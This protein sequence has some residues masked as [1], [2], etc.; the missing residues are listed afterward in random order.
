MVCLVQNQL[1]TADWVG[2]PYIGATHFVVGVVLVVVAVLWCACMTL[3][4]STRLGVCGRHRVV[5][6]LLPW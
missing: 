6:L 2:L 1:L 4:C 5:V 3:L